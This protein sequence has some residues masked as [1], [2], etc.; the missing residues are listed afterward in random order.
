[1]A[2]IV[3]DGA[4]APRTMYAENRRFTPMGGDFVAVAAVP[5]PSYDFCLANLDR[6]SIQ[7]NQKKYRKDL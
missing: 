3:T 5:V 2:F 4:A 6:A 1:M 7:Q